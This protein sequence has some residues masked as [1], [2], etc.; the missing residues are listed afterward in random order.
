MVCVCVET[1]RV[2]C[3][4]RWSSVCFQAKISASKIYQA[5]DAS[6]LTLTEVNKFA[7]AAAQK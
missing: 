7:F 1:E 5:N 6:D 2:L 3:C 4:E